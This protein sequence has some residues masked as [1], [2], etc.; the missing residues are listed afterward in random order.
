[1][2]LRRAPLKTTHSSCAAIAGR[3]IKSRALNT[4]VANSCILDNNGSA[5]YSLPLFGVSS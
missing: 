1:L 4:L 2:T 3:E 5:S